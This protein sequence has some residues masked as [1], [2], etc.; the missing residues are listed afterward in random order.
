MGLGPLE[1]VAEKAPCPLH[2][3]RLQLEGSLCESEVGLTRQ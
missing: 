3:V 2:H 1:K